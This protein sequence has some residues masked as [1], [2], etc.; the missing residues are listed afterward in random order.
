MQR[1]EAPTARSV[2]PFEPSSLRGKP[3]RKSPPRQWNK[4]DIP[5]SGLRQGQ[6]TP[7]ITMLAS[8]RST[9]EPLISLSRILVH[10]R[11]ALT[12][13]LRTP[14]RSTE[15]PFDLQAWYLLTFVPPDAP[16]RSGTVVFRPRYACRDSHSIRDSPLSAKVDVHE[17][18][19]EPRNLNRRK[20]CGFFSALGKGSASHNDNCNRVTKETIA[21]C[22]VFRKRHP[23]P[24]S[25][26]ACFPIQ[27]RSQPK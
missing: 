11:R 26:L 20:K 1:P 25:M 19:Y 14:N 23:I 8:H 16:P 17:H 13:M 4:F 9:H 12:E 24:S 15:S 6:P 7:S 27:K 3:A 10:R 21:V 18:G 22:T 5:L 2:V